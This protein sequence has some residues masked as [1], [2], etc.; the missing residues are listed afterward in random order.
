MNQ[1]PSYTPEENLRRIKIQKIK[2]VVVEG[3]DDVP[4]YESCLTSLAPESADYDV[5]FSGGKI[6][7]K[8]FIQE[9]NPEN[10]IF[11]IDK[12]FHDIEIEHERLIS[13]RRYSI[14]NYFI[15]EDVI[16]HA[17]QFAL[18]CKFSD[19]KNVFSLEQFMNEVS[20]AVSDLIKVIFYYQKN[21]LSK[22]FTGEAPKWSD[23][24]LCDNSNWTLCRDKINFLISKLTSDK[25]TIDDANT[26]FASQFNTSGNIAHDF[27]GKMLKTSLQ[28]YIRNEILR[29]KPAAKG[30]F[31]D[32]EDMRVQLSAAMQFSPEL[33]DLLQ[34]VIEFIQINSN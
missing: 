27:P 32:P 31:R 7:I 19:I 30:K 5:I 4:I 28:R 2:F 17:L 3:S 25:F 8:N 33:K 13:L 9:N 11:I 22:T 12:D 10:A 23:E 18:N 20:N 6:N 29:I 26:F 1:I 14:E 16:C 34:P 21:E 15:C 24:F